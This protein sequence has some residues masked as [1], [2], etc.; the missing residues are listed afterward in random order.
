[1]IPK[2][3]IEKGEILL[4]SL[5]VYIKWAERYTEDMEMAFPIFRAKHSAC[6]SHVAQFY[7]CRMT[8][9]LKGTSYRRQICTFF[10]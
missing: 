8:E 6:L 3:R 10:S 7:A 9:K 4:L 5:S 2:C 1:M